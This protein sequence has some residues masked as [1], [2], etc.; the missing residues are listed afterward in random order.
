MLLKNIYYHIDLKKELDLSE[1][2]HNFLKH[3][4]QIALDQ[5]IGNSSENLIGN[6]VCYNKI[7][8]ESKKEIVDKCE[9]EYNAKL[10]KEKEIIDRQYSSELDKLTNQVKELEKIIEKKNK[11]IKTKSSKIKTRE[12]KNERIKNE[13]RSK[14]D[15]LT[16]KI[17]EYETIIENQK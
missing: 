13:C 3:R 9:Q 6:E 2:M 1:F 12:N 17:K 11:E 16:N 8:I 5:S 7:L 14:L 10:E 4:F 15:G